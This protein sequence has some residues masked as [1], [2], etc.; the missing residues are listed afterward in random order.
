MEDRVNATRFKEFQSSMKWQILIFQRVGRRPGEGGIHANVAFVARKRP[1]DDATLHW[2]RN[3]VVSLFDPLEG[4][5]LSHD[6]G[7]NVE[8][9]V[10]RSA[11]G[12]GQK[13][14]HHFGTAIVARAA[15]RHAA[16]SAAAT[17]AAGRRSARG[18]HSLSSAAPCLVSVCVCVGPQTKNT[19]RQGGG[20]RGLWL[21]GLPSS[22]LLHTHT[23][24]PNKFD[25]R[26]TR[27]L[28]HT[29]CRKMVARKTLDTRTTP[30]LSFRR[31]FSFFL[32]PLP[33]DDELAK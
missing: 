4:N 24:R 22:L 16:D 7:A 19:G 20:A 3:A 26:N 25:K 6:T 13:T 15:A 27:R 18:G 10:G 17:A 8:E 21:P 2:L 11:T 5:L 31:L 1:K 33:G 32:S 30:S 28:H 12:R 29:N 14:H 23:H 9:R